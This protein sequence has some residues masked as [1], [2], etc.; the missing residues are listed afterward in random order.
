MA[1]K[2]KQER[3]SGQGYL[4]EYVKHTQKEYAR[5]AVHE[6]RAEWGFQV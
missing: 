4:H 1:G 2:G 3:R 5:G 6:N